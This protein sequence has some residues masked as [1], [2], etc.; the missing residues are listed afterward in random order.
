MKFLLLFKPQWKSAMHMFT[1]YQLTSW[2]DSFNEK[3]HL[4]EFHAC[5]KRLSYQIQANALTLI[6]GAGVSLLSFVT[7]LTKYLTLCYA[8]II[9]YVLN[10]VCNILSKIFDQYLKQQHRK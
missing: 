10:I 5:F 6:S 8:S 1:I 7:L 3:Y 9:I 4:K 2:M